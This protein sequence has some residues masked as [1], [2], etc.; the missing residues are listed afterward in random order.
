MAR[1]LGID[2]GSRVTG[3]GVLD[4]DGPRLK[5]VTCGC[6][7]PRAT[8]LGERLGTIFEEISQLIAEFVPDEMAIEQVFMHRNAQ[9]ALKLGQ[10]RGAAIVAAASGR[11]PV[12]EY[13]PTQIKQAATGRGHAAKSQ[14]QH[15]VQVLLRLEAVPPTDAADAL[16]VA[17][18]HG[19]HRETVLRVGSAHE[20]ALMR[21]GVGGARRRRRARAGGRR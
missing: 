4:V 12:H 13:S 11:L 18:A 7:T 20:A 10:A 3:Y 5:Y 19:H 17:I 14:V 21:Q 16:A 8:A 9:S 15:M 2:P 6:I 1:I